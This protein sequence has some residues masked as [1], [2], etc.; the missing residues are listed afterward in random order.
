MKQKRTNRFVQKLLEQIQAIQLSCSGYDAGLDSEAIRLATC[1]RIL[2]HKTAHS[3]PLLDHLKMKAV[4][5]LSSDSGHNDFKGYVAIEINLGSPNPVKCR[6]RLGKQFVPIP[7]HEW[8]HQQSVHIFK[9]RRYTRRDLVLVAT[10]QE[11]GAHVDAKVEEFYADLASGTQGF[12]IDGSNLVYP[13]NKAPHDQ[14]IQQS[15]KNTHLAM[16]RQFAH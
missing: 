7:F 3:T 15:A 4:T 2:F 16:L 8:W 14:S 11:G 6:P 5:M 13:N 9:D 10:N 12:S 1:M